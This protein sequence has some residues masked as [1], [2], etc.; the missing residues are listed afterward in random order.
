MVPMRIA[1]QSVVMAH[2]Y[3]P[4]MPV[5][6]TSVGLGFVVLREAPAFPLAYAAAYTT[7]KRQHMLLPISAVE[8]AESEVYG[9]T[10]LTGEGSNTV[11]LAEQAS[12]AAMLLEFGLYL[13]SARDPDREA[14][15]VFRNSRLYRTE[16][17]WMHMWAG[18]G[19]FYSLVTMELP[20]AGM[21]ILN[22]DM[23]REL[24]M[25]SANARVGLTSRLAEN[26]ARYGH[27]IGMHIAIEE[28]HRYPQGTIVMPSLAVEIFTRA[29]SKIVFPPWMNRQPE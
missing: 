6:P 27:F 13:R 26:A 12:I 18:V 8:R 29:K 15:D 23:L 28:L 24:K 20:A 9:V 3:D 4:A 21:I 7:V 17:F 11:V 16:S 1:D 10:A 19:H 2:P 5:D 22:D 25:E 14:L